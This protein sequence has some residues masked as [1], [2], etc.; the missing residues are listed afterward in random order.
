MQGIWEFCAMELLEMVGGKGGFSVVAL[1]LSSVI[2]FRHEI[3]SYVSFCNAEISLVVTH[4]CQL[5]LFF[6]WWLG[7]VRM[8]S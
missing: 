4:W 8:S 6:C 3:V 5:V 2:A 1:H 7:F